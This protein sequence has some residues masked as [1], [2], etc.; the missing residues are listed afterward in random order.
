MTIQQQRGAWGEER[1]CQFLMQHGL[2]LITRNYHC[3]YGEIDLI[4]QHEETLVFVEV[5]YRR[6]TAYGSSAESINLRKQQR[7]I[8]TGQHYLQTLLH[9]PYCR[10]DVIAINGAQVEWIQNAFQASP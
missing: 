2:Q 3:R 4:M 1:A 8:L 7:L 10:F 5:R 9:I 6:S